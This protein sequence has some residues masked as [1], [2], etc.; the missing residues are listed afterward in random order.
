MLWAPLYNLCTR[1][2][3]HHVFCERSSLHCQWNDFSIEEQTWMSRPI[4]TPA[5]PLSRAIEASPSEESTS[6]CTMIVSLRGVLDPLAAAGVA[7]ADL[8]GAVDTPTHSHALLY[9]PFHLFIPVRT[10]EFDSTRLATVVHT[11]LRAALLH[12][13]EGRRRSRK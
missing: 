10:L 12:A 5:A 1:P 3:G 2:R 9:S 7:G 4:H 8:V 11:L 13:P 6:S